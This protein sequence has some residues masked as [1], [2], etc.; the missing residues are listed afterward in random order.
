ML[1]YY[2]WGEAWGLGMA[3]NCIKITTQTAT[4]LDILAFGKLIGE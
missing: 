1:F 2:T 3:T 4:S